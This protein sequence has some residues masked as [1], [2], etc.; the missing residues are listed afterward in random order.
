MDKTAFVNIAV[1][2]K[3]GSY[4]ANKCKLANCT[5]KNNDAAA[6]AIEQIIFNKGVHLRAKKA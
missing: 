6:I 5:A 3:Y 4:F 1:L 2:T